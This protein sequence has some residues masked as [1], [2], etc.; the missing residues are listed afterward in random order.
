[1]TTLGLHGVSMEIIFIELHILNLIFTIYHIMCMSF[2]GRR[3]PYYYHM[4]KFSSGDHS[5]ETPMDRYLYSQVKGP[6][7]TLLGGKDHYTTRVFTQTGY[8]IGD[9]LLLS[10]ILNCNMH[11]SMLTLLQFNDRIK[12]V[13]SFRWLF[14]LAR[15]G[16]QSG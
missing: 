8:T 14:L 4:K 9:S 11:Y 7:S 15:L 6:L 1:M 10:S 13:K 2:Q 5:F 12:Q 16:D 3:L